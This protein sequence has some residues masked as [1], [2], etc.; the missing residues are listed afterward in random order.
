MSATR[1]PVASEN[2][3]AG[4]PI[5]N[6]ALGPAF[7]VFLLIPKIVRL[8]HNKPAWFAFRILLG[9]AGTALVIFPL[10][11]GNNWV[12]ALAGLALFMAAILLPAARSEA[13]AAQ[14]AQELG[15]LIVLNGG[16]YQPENA[17]AVAVK[18]FVRAENIWVLDAAFKPLLIVP[19]AAISSANAAE[20]LGQWIF[21][22]RWNEHTTDFHYRGVFAGHLAGVAESTIRSVMHPALP[23]LPQKHAAG[24]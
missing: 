17:S 8:R 18:L 21:R 11:K 1:T 2:E 10:S 23:I 15:A 6:L 3:N 24:A 13:S 19:I 22:I 14:K 12:P 4:G 20:S 5:R 9:A 7:A 16:E